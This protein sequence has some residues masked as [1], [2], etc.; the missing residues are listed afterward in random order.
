MFSN[1]SNCI[2][3]PWSAASSPGTADAARGA[4]T[5]RGGCRACIGSPGRPRS[6][7]RDEDL[8]PSGRNKRR[9]CVAFPRGYSGWRMTGAC[10]RR[11]SPAAN[12]RV[13]A[14]QPKSG[15]VSN[16]PPLR[17]LP[18]R[19]RPEGCSRPRAPS[20]SPG[21]YIGPAIGETPRNCAREFIAVSSRQR[22]ESKR[23]HMSVSASKGRPNATSSKPARAANSLCGTSHDS[24]GRR[25]KRSTR[26]HTSWRADGVRPESARRHG[27]RQRQGVHDVASR[28]P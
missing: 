7:R 18:S 22:L 13:V 16:P 19:G 23:I 12:A 2:S 15:G 8:S 5:K 21:R 11:S 1:V 28:A 25:T 14:R 4:A 17:P 3:H 20:A 26:T 24:T 9:V 27:A 10:G 6:H